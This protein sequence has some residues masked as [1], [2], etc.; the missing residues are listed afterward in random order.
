[1][2]IAGIIQI[3]SGVLTI[4]YAKTMPLPLKDYMAENLRSNYTG[5]L[6]VGYLDRR[7]DRYVDWLQ[8]N[9]K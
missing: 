3:V 2:I 6:E 5:G 7:F 4:V 8:I 9:V 1:L